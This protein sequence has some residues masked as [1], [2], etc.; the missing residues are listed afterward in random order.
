MKVT[1]EMIDEARPLTAAEREAQGLPV[2]PSESVLRRVAKH[3][4]TPEPEAKVS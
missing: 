1:R 4:V 3:F 2:A